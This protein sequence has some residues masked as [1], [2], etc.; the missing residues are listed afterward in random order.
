M[1]P[2]MAL[3]GHLHL[4]FLHAIGEFRLSVN[5]SIHL[6]LQTVL[7]LLSVEQIV[8]LGR[9]A[10]CGRYFRKPML[11][12]SGLLPPVVRF[13][14]SAELGISHGKVEAIPVV[15]DIVPFSP[16]GPA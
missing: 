12:F 2:G 8:C 9:N 14:E 7:E 4:R 16:K 6:L 15:P 11:V 13:F 1:P 5:R 3:H 10:G